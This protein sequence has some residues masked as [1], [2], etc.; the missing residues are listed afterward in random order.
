MGSCFG[1][2]LKRSES[3]SPTHNGVGKPLCRIVRHCCAYRCQGRHQVLAR[4][5]RCDWCVGA[6]SGCTG[7]G[8]GVDTAVPVCSAG[9]A[10]G[11]ASRRDATSCC[12]WFTS[13]S[14]RSR[15]SS[16][17]SSRRLRSAISSR[18]MSTSG[19][20]TV[21]PVS[22]PVGDVFV[23]SHAT[24]HILPNGLPI[25][26]DTGQENVPASVALIAAYGAALKPFSECNGGCPEL[27]SGLSN[28]HPGGLP[29][30]TA[31]RPG[32]PGHVPPHCRA[33]VAPRVHGCTVRP[34][35]YSSQSRHNRR[36]AG[37]AERPQ[38]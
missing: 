1:W 8:S 26:R 4:R 22:C 24:G 38:S 35:V 11:A 29:M 31:V 7:R 36:P 2:R 28:A 14:S 27:D 19:L 13:C 20:P 15:S 25:G 18:R 17:R 30:S 21:L 23:P 37:G 12:A 6:G 33:C 9:G 16:A 32:V 3:D 10:L 34:P 5:R